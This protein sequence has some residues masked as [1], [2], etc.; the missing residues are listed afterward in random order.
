MEGDPAEEGRINDIKD[1]KPM[2]VVGGKSSWF[3]GMLG[4]NGCGV[5]DWGAGGG[6]T[7]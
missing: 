3:P 2:P 5:T 1:G 6:P 4:I 7:P